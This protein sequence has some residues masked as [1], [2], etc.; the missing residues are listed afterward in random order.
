MNFGEFRYKISSISMLLSIAVGIFFGGLIY[1]YLAN[2]VKQ[3]SPEDAAL[4]PLV[5][6]KIE[7]EDGMQLNYRGDLKKLSN[8]IKRYRSQGYESVLLV[9]ASHLHAIADY[10]TN[11]RLAISYVKKSL[12]T[13]QVVKQV[14]Q[15]SY[16]NG[17]FVEFLLS[18]LYLKEQGALPNNLIFGFVYDDLRDSSVRAKL[19][20]YEAPMAIND[21]INEKGT[22][23]LLSE[24]SKTRSVELKESN[25]LLQDKIEKNVVEA[26]G[27]VWDEFNYRDKV[28]AYL[29]YTMMRVSADIFGS[30]Q[31]AL[32]DRYFV[33]VPPEVN[34][35]IADRNLAA[36]E[37]ILKLA[38]EDEVS[39]MVYRAPHPKYEGKLYH[40]SNKYEKY[41]EK[42]ESITKKYRAKFK[43]WEE[44]LPSKY[45][46]IGNKIDV[47][48]FQN[49]G[50]VK[51]GETVAS[52]L[53]DTKGNI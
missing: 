12:R 30:L 24:Q 40:N 47:F 6:P 10:A 34:S 5:R 32:G 52:Y 25:L 33:P 39:V 11:D 4:G 20:A 8:H 18:Y 51:L 42:V 28:K 9:G 46:L 37:T 19:V 38:K 43:D 48:H 26:I 31:S 27:G 7:T 17:N 49:K 41:T 29:S 44:L 2:Q 23:I 14:L 13:R 16:P 35:A 15:L 45:F 3:F 22:K 1:T 50:H 36:L 21:A 53:A